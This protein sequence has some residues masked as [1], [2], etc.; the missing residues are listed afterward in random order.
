MSLFNDLIGFVGGSQ[1]SGNDGTS[2]IHP[3]MDMPNLQD[4]FRVTNDTRYTYNVGNGNSFNP[5]SESSNSI[6][7]TVQ[8]ILA[9][10]FALM[11]IFV[12]VKK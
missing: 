7:P 8:I 6:S 2:N 11:I 1:P 5:F 9:G 10:S 3:S 4:L 12:V